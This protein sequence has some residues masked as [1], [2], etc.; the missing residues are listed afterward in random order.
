MKYRR[1]LEL[2]EKMLAKAKE[3]YEFAEAQHAQAV[4]ENIRYPKEGESSIDHETK[5]EVDKALENLKTR[6]KHYQEVF[7]I[8]TEV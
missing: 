5:I 3:E 1:Q 2:A 7:E 8:S 4:A 6:Q